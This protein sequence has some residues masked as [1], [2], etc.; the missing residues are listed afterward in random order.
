[1]LA[2]VTTQI[3]QLGGDRDRAH[4]RGDNVFGRSDICY[5]RAVVIGVRVYVKHVRSCLRFN[6][7]DNARNRLRL[8]AF[9]EVW[10]TLDK[11]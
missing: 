7:R 6:R 3:N 8:T 5:N 4:C 10:Y 2:R 11:H 9:A 1:M